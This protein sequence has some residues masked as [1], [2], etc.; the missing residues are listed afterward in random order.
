VK[1]LDL[2]FILCEENEKITKGQLIPIVPAKVSI[3]Q[4]IFK[5]KFDIS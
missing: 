4:I 2:A 3:E 5:V 1:S